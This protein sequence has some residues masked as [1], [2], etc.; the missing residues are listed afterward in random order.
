VPKPLK[1]DPSVKVDYDI[2]YR[3]QLRADTHPGR[4]ARLFHR[5]RPSELLGDGR[6]PGQ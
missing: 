3:G 5:H 6:F 4:H 1:S 2:V